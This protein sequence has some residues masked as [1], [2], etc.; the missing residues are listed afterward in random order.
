[1]SKLR[2]NTA[3]KRGEYASALD[4][5]YDTVTAADTPETELS[6]SELARLI[7]AFLA[8]EKTSDREFFIRR[9]YL[10]EPVFE[11]AREF[12]VMPERVSS[13]LSQ[14]KERLARFLTK[15]GYDI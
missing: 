12:S 8:S 4:E 6:A 2:E 14:Q 3:E 13:R 1:M 9:Y 15:E 7:N 10:G 5:L 11:I